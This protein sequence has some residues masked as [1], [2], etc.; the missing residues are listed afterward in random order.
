MKRSLDQEKT[1]RPALRHSFLR[2]R[3]ATAVLAMLYLVL[4]S[5]LALGFY[6]AT[7]TAVQVSNNDSQVSRA[8]LAS[9]SGLDFMRYHLAHVSIGAFSTD[10]TTELTNDLKDRLEPTPN[11]ILSG[12]GTGLTV[13]ASGTVFNIP[14]EPGKWIKL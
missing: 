14:A 3:G 5:T 2:R 1:M 10:V 6:A 4:F 13:A 8:F 11:M 7:T 12:N 9:E